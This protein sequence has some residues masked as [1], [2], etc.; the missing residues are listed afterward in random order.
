[1][2]GAPCSNPRALGK[3]TNTWRIEREAVA[4]IMTGSKT[5]IRNALKLEVDRLEP[6][7][8][9]RKQVIETF[10]WS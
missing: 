3:V 6:K 5:K 10:E 9:N 8:K 2:G 1:M 7:A 4:A